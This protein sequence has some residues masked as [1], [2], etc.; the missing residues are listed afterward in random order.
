MNI[1]ENISFSTLCSLK[2]HEMAPFYCELNSE[3]ELNEISEFLD[4]EKIKHCVLGDGTNIV[5]T[6]KFNGLVIKNKLKGIKRE[7]TKIEVASGENWHSFVDLSLSEELFGL[8]NLA[9]IPGTVGA[10]PIQNIGAYGSEISDFISEVRVYDFENKTIQ[11]LN[12]KECGFGYRTSIFKNTDRYLVISVTFELL[13]EPNINHTYE[14]LKKEIQNIGKT[15]NDLKPR[16]VFNLVSKIRK[17]R[18]PDHILNPNVGSFFKNVNLT[19]QEILEVD[20]P[21]GTPI[22]KKQGSI[23]ISSAYLIEKAGW[24]GKRK[25]NVGVSDLHSLVLV[26]Y[27]DIK[28]KEILDFADEIMSDVYHKTKIKLQIEPNLI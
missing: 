3:E 6:G 13:S 10:G 21:I 26:A 12:N 28:G 4:R 16:D 22:F 24:K 23:K 8:E 20:L 25:G 5:P 18:L 17:K 9:L 11:T 2:I 7:G 19:E 15:E 27:E 1:S 14:A